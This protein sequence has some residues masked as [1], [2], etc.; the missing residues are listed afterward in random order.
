MDDENRKIN[1][2]LK[3][4]I[5]TLIQIIPMNIYIENMFSLTETGVVMKICTQFRRVWNTTEFK[6]IGIKFIIYWYFYC[7]SETVDMFGIKVI[8]LLRIEFM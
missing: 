6:L 7:N 3:G 2:K 5:F 1:H 8:V 4:R